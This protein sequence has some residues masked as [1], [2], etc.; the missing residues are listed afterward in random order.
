MKSFSTTIHSTLIM[1]PVTK[2]PSSQ[3]LMELI[4]QLSNRV[5]RWSLVIA[6]DTSF[7]STAHITSLIQRSIIDPWN[8]LSSTIHEIYTATEPHH[9]HVTDFQ[10]IPPW[11][12]LLYNQTSPSTQRFIN[13]SSTQQFILI[14]FH[15]NDSFW[16]TLNST[17]HEINTSSE[18]QYLYSSVW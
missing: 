17:I 8:T 10:P 14:S 5:F 13:E 4:L 18:R 9:Q 16:K 1:I 3:R 6:T 11:K 12:W 15:L 7:S 2:E